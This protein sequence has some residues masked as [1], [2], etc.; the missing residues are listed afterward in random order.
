[1]T[2]AASNTSLK[3]SQAF[4]RLVSKIASAY[5]SGQ[6]EPRDDNIEDPESI[7]VTAGELSLSALRYG[8]NH[9]PLVLLHG[10]NNNA[11]SW[12]RVGH[13]LKNTRSVVSVSQRGHGRSDAPETGYGL[14]DTTSDLVKLLDRLGLE[15][16][17]L[18][19]HSWGG[20]VATHFAA[21]YPTRVK[22]LILADPV[23]PSG[24]NRLIN[25]FPALV[26]ASLRAERGPYR[27]AQELEAAGK[28]LIYLRNWKRLDQ[29]L[30]QENF[31][32]NHDGSYHHVLSDQAF[33]EV[34]R[35]AIHVDIRGQVKAINCP[36]LLML[37]TLTISFYPGELGAFRRVFPTARIHRVRGDHT[38][39][40]SNPFETATLIG[41]FLADVSGPASG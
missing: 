9:P 6:I 14:D 31:V 22:P 7:N 33:E 27:N 8:S 29:R 23:S 34:F 2:T 20:K 24:L 13:A 16:I 26:T 3:T 39:I 38:F 19:G 12:I 37:P 40:H 28:H 1:M 25:R 30:W 36:I 21:N 18:A 41:S 17:D 11:W 10:V 32:E 4:H 15:R 35:K 5:S